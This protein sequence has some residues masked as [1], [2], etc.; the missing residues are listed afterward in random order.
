[1]RLSKYFGASPK[2]RLG[3][4]DNFDLEEARREKDKEFNM[5]KP[6]APNAEAA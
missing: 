1:M 3:L 2:F 4:Q 5:I 6:Y